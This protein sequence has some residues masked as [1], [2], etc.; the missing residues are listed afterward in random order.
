[1][2]DSHAHRSAEKD[3]SICEAY[4]CRNGDTHQ[5]TSWR[6]GVRE[7]QWAPCGRPCEPATS[8]GGVFPIPCCH[9]PVHS[10]TCPTFPAG[11]STSG[12]GGE[13]S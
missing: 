9:G 3:V 13:P 10:D 7:E 12:E 11:Q 1:M 6:S 4:D 5:G 2:P 8:A